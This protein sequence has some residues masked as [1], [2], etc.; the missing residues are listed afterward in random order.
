MSIS[1]KASTV[2]FTHKQG[3]YLAYIYYYTKVN[4]RLPA[5]A[6]IQRYFNV[7]PPTVHQMLVV[8]EGK[9]LLEKTAHQSRAIT[10]LVPINQLPTDW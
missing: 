5:Q 4:G 10:V 3:Q 8:L 2:E 6:D 7:T 1:S 9:G